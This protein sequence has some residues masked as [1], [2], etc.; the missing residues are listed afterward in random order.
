M[1][2]ETLQFILKEIVEDHDAGLT[3]FNGLET[4]FDAKALKTFPSVIIVSITHNGNFG[5]SSQPS[6]TFTINGFSADSYP[7]DRAPELY[8]QILARSYGFMRDI[9]L[10][11]VQYGDKSLTRNGEVLDFTM[12]VPANMIDYKDEKEYN[13]AGHLFTITLTDNLRIEE[14]CVDDRFGTVI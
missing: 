3:F 7:V 1:T 10:R 12:P 6:Q 9:E 4:D 14:C 2:L 13:A 5:N 8:N 11:M